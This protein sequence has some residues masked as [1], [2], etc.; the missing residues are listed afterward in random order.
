V[1][2]KRSGVFI[3]LVRPFCSYFCLS[4]N[5]PLRAFP[6]FISRIKVEK[7]GLEFTGEDSCGM[8]WMEKREEVLV[9]VYGELKVV[10]KEVKS[11]GV[12]FDGREFAWL[13]TSQISHLNTL[14]RKCNC[15]FFKNGDYATEDNV[16]TWSPSSQQCP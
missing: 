6:F 10:M 13:W 15:A 1:Q 14:V 8:S 11:G 9:T 7:T 5:Q 2:H 4:L 12:R 16:K 3:S